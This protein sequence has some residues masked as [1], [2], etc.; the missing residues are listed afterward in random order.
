[1][2]KWTKILDLVLRGTNDASISFDDLCGLLE[3]MGFDRRVR[4]SHNIFRKE[5]VREMPNLQR[6]GAKAK[7]YQVRQVRDIIVKN[8]LGEEI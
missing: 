2:S 8:R 3:R 1:M 4:G 7:S 5:G 6:S